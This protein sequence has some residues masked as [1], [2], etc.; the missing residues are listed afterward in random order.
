MIRRPLEVMRNEMLL[1]GGV[2]AL[3]ARRPVA[4][5]SQLWRSGA[6]GRGEQLQE[7]VELHRLRRLPKLVAKAH[8]ERFC[9]SSEC[10][11][12]RQA[13]DLA[14][15]RVRARVEDVQGRG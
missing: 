13:A 15:L 2:L 14:L 9:P 7:H 5:A 10:S 12:Q 8:L 11:S 4:A 6:H 1:G 3:G